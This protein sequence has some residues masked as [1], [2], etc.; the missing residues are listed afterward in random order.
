MNLQ[1]KL[2]ELLKH[3]DQNQPPQALTL[4]LGDGYLLNYNPVFKRLRTAF[5]D[6]GYS[7]TDQDFCNYVVLPYVSLK[8]ILAA[9]KVPYFDNV[10]VLKEIEADHPQKFK[11]EE[12]VRVKANYTLHE[13]S[14][15]VAEEYLKNL[16]FKVLPISA[17]SQIAFKLI[18][19]ESFANTTEALAN[20]FNKTDAQKIF[21]ELNTYVSL[22]IKT[23][24]IFKQCIDTFGWNSIYRLT[25]LSYLYSNCL[26]S[27]I[28][29]NS[30]LQVLNF[31]FKNEVDF[32]KAKQAP[33]LRK[34]FNHAFEL[35]L[36]FRV[37]TTGFY[38]QLSGL[39]TDVFK[40]LQL[41][42]IDIY[43]K[44]DTIEKFLS[45]TET[46]FSK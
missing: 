5:L 46:L 15:C 20:V 31:V 29:Q 26:Y 22:S 13:S 44:S 32:Q 1:I 30:F 4:S 36:D 34:L 6:F 18:M 12:L 19:A 3:H 9:K 23:E 17:E 28:K 37:Q 2:A 11:C 38:C 10:S 24:N 21:Y 35:S 16:N 14:H 42:I 41:D 39:N 27:D 25:F 40:L 43:K 7:Y 45:Q 8:K 33:V